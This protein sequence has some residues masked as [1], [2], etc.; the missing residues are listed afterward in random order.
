M[1]YKDPIN[2]IVGLKFKKVR[3]K[4]DFSATPFVIQTT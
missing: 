4:I 2:S 1:R 3:A